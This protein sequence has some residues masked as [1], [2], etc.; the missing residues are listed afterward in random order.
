[1][2]SL[3]IQHTLWYSEYFP[4]QSLET[5]WANLA[6]GKNIPNIMCLWLC[7]RIGKNAHGCDFEPLGASR[8][9]ESRTY[10]LCFTVSLKRELDT[11]NVSLFTCSAGFDAGSALLS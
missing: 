10:I 11:R 4:L 1:M 5:V 7:P 3:I 6:P 8:K 2:L 9:G